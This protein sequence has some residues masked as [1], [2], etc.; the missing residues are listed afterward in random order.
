MLCWAFC[1]NQFNIVGFTFTETPDIKTPPFVVLNKL[2]DKKIRYA[3]N[4]IPVH[5]LT[6][7]V[8]FSLI[9]PYP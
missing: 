7:K 9:G 8:L 6:N 4:D 5:T 2:F 3:I 1:I